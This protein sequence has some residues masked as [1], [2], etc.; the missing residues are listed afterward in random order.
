MKREKVFAPVLC[1]AIPLSGCGGPTP[2][3]CETSLTCRHDGTCAAIPLC[4]SFSDKWYC[5]SGLPAPRLRN[6]G[7]AE[8]HI[9]RLLGYE[10]P[11]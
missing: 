10:L 11:E 1:A 7:T 5:V 2:F 9:F 4:L 6:I 8:E 3:S